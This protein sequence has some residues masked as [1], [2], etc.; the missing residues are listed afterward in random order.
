MDLRIVGVTDIYKNFAASAYAN[1]A[2]P[3]GVVVSKKDQVN[4]SLT[5]NDY[6]FARRAVLSVP[7]IRIEIVNRIS[8]EI[9][10]GTYNISSKD[11]AARILGRA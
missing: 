4:I 7:D 11:I 9:E 2:A 6:T 10:A 3:N 8:S 5:G 1:S